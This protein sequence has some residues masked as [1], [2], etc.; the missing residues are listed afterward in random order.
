MYVFWR[1]LI[2]ETKSCEITTTRHT[3]CPN[4]ILS[5]MSF[6][7]KDRCFR[8][9]SKTHIQV[10]DKKAKRKCVDSVGYHAK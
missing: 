9:I 2:Y 6:N 1:Q 8:C 5:N 3:L 7:K 4:F 10:H